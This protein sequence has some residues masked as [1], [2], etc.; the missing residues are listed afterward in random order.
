M[1]IPRQRVG[2]E[3]GTQGGPGQRHHSPGT[4]SQQALEGGEPQEIRDPRRRLP[5]QKPDPLP[6]PE[7]RNTTS[8]SMLGAKAQ[9]TLPAAKMTVVSRK[10]LRTPRPS[11]RGPAIMVASV[12]VTKNPVT[13]QLNN[14]HPA[15][16]GGDLGQASHHRQRVEGS[17]R[18]E[19]D[20]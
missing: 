1:K 16:V 19:G 11:M 4:T 14:I 12:E 9:A 2:D 13:N 17:K 6:D 7:A 3:G 8:A 10:V 5:P 15:E 20:Q 18:D